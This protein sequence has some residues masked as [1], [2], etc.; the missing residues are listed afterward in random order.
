MSNL[1]PIPTQI[2]KNPALEQVAE[3]LYR[4]MELMSQ[5]YTDPLD[6]YKKLHE[7]GFKWGRNKVYKYVMVAS[8]WLVK[9]GN[10]TKKAVDQRHVL[11]KQA[12][13]QQ[14][15]LNAEKLHAINTRTEAL[16][17]L[18]Q[19]VPIEKLT[20]EEQQWA[21]VEPNK[22]LDTLT[23][24]SAVILKAQERESELYGYRSDRTILIQHDRG[25]KLKYEDE[26][27]ENY[28]KKFRN[29][30]YEEVADDGITDASNM[31][32]NQEVDSFMDA[33]VEPGGGDEQ[34]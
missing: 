5:G 31:D 10:E 4:V 15:T 16:K 24:M 3:D 29:V 20:H 17:K 22:F 33:L 32:E 8:Q 18:E 1:V 28:L 23:K 30:D 7:D 21:A 9:I 2:S 26:L 34:G 19:G 11:V 14:Q 27:N 13:H 6:V 12:E 25:V